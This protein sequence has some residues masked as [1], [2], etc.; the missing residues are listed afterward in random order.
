M[1][2]PAWETSVRTKIERKAEKL[3]SDPY[4]FG[5]FI[6]NEMHWYQPNSMASKVLANNAQS[7]GKKEYI[8]LLKKSLKDI[9]VFNEQT[10]SNF[11]SWEAVL[12][13]QK[14]VNV[15]QLE[16]INIEF[17]EK[18]CH[19]YFST[20]KNAIDEL[21]PGNLFLGCRWHVD[22][23]HRNKYNVPIGAEYLDIVS[24]NQYDNELNTFTYPGKDSFDKPYIISEFNFGALDTGKFYPGLGHASDQRNRGEK[25]QNFIESALRDPN[26]VGAHWFMWGNS[27]TAGRSVV[28]ENANCGLVSETDTPHYEMLDYLRKTTYNLYTYRTN[29]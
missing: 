26:C 13:N 10:N 19:V 8:K 3:N 21:S 16:A 29:N 6:D 17:Y 1:F 23:K 12:N 24:F 2:D 15:D 4:F 28:G 9:A 11:D 14:K 5:Y 22:G 18:L 27:T 25:Y 20:I 7:I